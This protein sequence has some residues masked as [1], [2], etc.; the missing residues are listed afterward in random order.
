M[1]RRAVALAKKHCQD[2][3]LSVLEGGYNPPGL[4]SAAI[5]HVT[6]LAE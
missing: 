3:L 1:T 5:A 4:A 2:R 6:V